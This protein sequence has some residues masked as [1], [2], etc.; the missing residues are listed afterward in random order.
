MAYLSRGID[1]IYG[2]FKG[3]SVISTLQIVAETNDCHLV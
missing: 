1:N 3:G 2:W